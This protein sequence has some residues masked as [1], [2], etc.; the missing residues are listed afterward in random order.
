[1]KSNVPL[2]QRQPY[3]YHRTAKAMVYV[4]FTVNRFFYPTT[5]VHPESVLVSSSAIV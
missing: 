2:Y 5:L 3:C 4:V 1:M